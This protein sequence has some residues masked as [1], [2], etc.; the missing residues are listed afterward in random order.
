MDPYNSPL[1]S[2]IVVPITHS[3]IPYLEPES[4]LGFRLEVGLVVWNEQSFKNITG[5]RNVLRT[6][7]SAYM[8]PRRLKTQPTMN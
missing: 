7:M 6:A 5:N 3:P 2:P 8:K 1:R 4:D